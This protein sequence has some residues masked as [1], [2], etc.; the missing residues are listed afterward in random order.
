MVSVVSEL[1]SGLDLK[2][3][4]QWVMTLLKDQIGSTIHALQMELR[5]PSEVPLLKD[6]GA[7]QRRDFKIKS[8]RPNT[9]K[10]IQNTVPESDVDD[11]EEIEEDED[12]ADE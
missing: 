9:I 12:F 10:P 2:S 8:D 11:L 1:F 5:S 6:S 3:R 7:P 4:Q